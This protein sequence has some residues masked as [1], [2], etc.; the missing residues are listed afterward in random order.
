MFG[1]GALAL[2]ACR[3]A[4]SPT[5]PPATS[6]SPSASRPSQRQAFVN[7]SLVAERP[8][9]PAATTSSQLLVSRGLGHR[10]GRTRSSYLGAVVRA[11]RCRSV[12]SAIPGVR[13][14]PGPRRHAGHQSLLAGRHIP[15]RRGRPAARGARRP[16]SRSSTLD[17][18]AT[19][20]GSSPSPW[21]APGFVTTLA[22]R[23]ASAARPPAGALRPLAGVSPRPP[24]PSPTAE[25]DTRA[26]RRRR[27]PRPG[28]AD[29]LVQPDGRPTSRTASSARPASPPTS[30]TSCARRSP[31]CRPASA[32]SRP[33][34]TSS[35]PRAQR[36]STCSTATCIGSSAWSTTCSRSPAS[37]PARPT[38]R[39]TR[40]TPASW[41]AGRSRRAARRPAD[42]VAPP[43]VEIDPGVPRPAPAGRQAALRAGDGQPARERRPLRRRGAPGGGPCTA[44]PVSGRRPA[45]PSGWRWRT[46]GP[47]VAAAE[48]SHVF[49]RFYRGRP[50]GQRGTGT[51]TG[52]GLA[53]VAEHV[54]L[55]GGTVWVEDGRR[56][57]A[58]ASWSSC[59]SSTATTERA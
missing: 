12:Q 26:S 4:R 38:S 7:A 10:P 23:R 6:S 27:R 46:E 3:W 29:H 52:L 47:G 21:S 2:S 45:T 35:H 9:P 15:A 48:R 49:E 41:S 53:L 17:D 32:C 8:A 19:P 44:G 11:P 43:A 40:S 36:R 1:L 56:A 13:A 24:W 14:D 50:S 59:P 5:S 18:L 37:T 54:R 25:L 58:P 42:G 22:R 57:A 28:G 34:A 51:G 33:T 55:N 39:S 16:T 20:C 30:A 31:P